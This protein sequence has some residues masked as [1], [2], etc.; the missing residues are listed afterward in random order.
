M[1]TLPSQSSHTTSSLQD[2]HAGHLRPPKGSQATGW[3][4]LLANAVSSHPSDL[5]SRF[6]NTL[7][8][9]FLE[10]IF[11]P[12]SPQKSYGQLASFSYRLQSLG[13]EKHVAESH[14]KRSWCD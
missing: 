12:M 5:L 1:G 6:S 4:V 3:L 8:S 13:F 11:T 9:Q 7:G 2:A 14:L 10:I